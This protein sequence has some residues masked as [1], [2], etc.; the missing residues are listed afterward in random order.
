METIRIID[1]D[2]FTELRFDLPDSRVNTLAAPVLEEVEQAL[3]ELAGRPDLKGLLVTS[4]KVGCFVAGADIHEIEAIDD[5]AIGAR[6]AT[7]G[8]EILHRFAELPCPTVAAIDGAALGG[9][10]ELALACDWRVASDSPKVKIGLPEVQLGILP[11]FGGC[12]RLPRLVGLEQGLA[13]ILG[14]RILDGRRA[15]KAG[16]IDAC[17]PQA[18]FREEAE[19]FLR[20]RIHG[21]GK[22]RPVRKRSLRA[23]L[24]EDYAPGRALAFSQARKGVMAKTHGHYP[25]AL[26]AVAVVKAAWTSPRERAFEIEA[27]AL[28]ETATTPECRALVAL[29][30]GRE[31]LRRESGV[32]GVA[33]GGRPVERAGVLGAGVMGGGI[34]QLIA[35]REIAVRMKDLEPR[36][37]ARGVQAAHAVWKEGLER[38][39]L[40][41][42]DYRRR[43]ACLTP[44]TTYH[45]FGRLDLVVEA[46]AERLSVKRALL[47]EVEGEVR[48]DAIFATNTSSLPIHEIAAEATHPERVIGLHF[49]NPVHRMPLV[50]VIRADSTSD[51]AT[52]A[53]VAFAKRL[54]K[55]P[56]VVADRPGFLV[57]RLLSPYLNE[58]ALILEAGSDVAGLDALMVDFG[59]PMGPFTLMDAVGL[60]ICQ[61]VAGVLHQ[62]FGDRMRPSALLARMVDH[63][64]LGD[65]QGRGFY[66]GKGKRRRVDDTLHYDLGTRHREITD[67]EAAVDRMVLAMVNEAAR[68]LEEEVVASPL[69]LDMAMVMG[70]GFPP[71]R[72]GLL[73]DADRRG[74]QAICDRLQQLAEEHGDRFTP[75]PLLVEMAE[76]GDGFYPNTN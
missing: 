56:V 13:M 49:F 55:V 33:G 64:R 43:A 50:E 34:A 32:P 24:I 51:E 73:R 20:E 40:S 15:L 63:D 69:H 1:H 59:M 47:A 18:I 57:N 25:S 3:A 76:R 66:K 38:H 7:R 5:A 19:R 52:L 28:G 70:T 17:I 61:E 16:L 75:A 36:F 26:R 53:T 71:Y 54:G 65:K 10:C 2:G 60:D 44:T 27:R 68:C 45:G 23:R 72:G 41:R 42:L 6:L 30:F 11:G 48:D 14:A 62:A 37:V 12:F 31:Q 67:R 35:D 4:A 21:A 29:Y 58:A 46:V 9:G 39:R 22:R 8:Q 74:V